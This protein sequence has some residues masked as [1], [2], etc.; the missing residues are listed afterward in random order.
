MASRARKVKGSGMSVRRAETRRTS[1][2]VDKR[3]DRYELL[4]LNPEAE[5][6]HTRAAII[7]ALLDLLDRPPDCN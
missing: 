5:I 1:V 2:R 6:P 7:R 3:F 4:Y